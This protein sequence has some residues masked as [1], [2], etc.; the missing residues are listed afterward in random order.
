MSQFCNIHMGQLHGVT[1]VLMREHCDHLDCAC[2]SLMAL[3]VITSM[4]YI[5]WRHW[6]AARR[7][8]PPAYTCLRTERVQHADLHAYREPTCSL[9][10]FCSHIN[11]GML[12]HHARPP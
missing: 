2:L 6:S 11:L 7:R 9:H 4:V 10:G 5:H 1:L 8:E 12:P 3:V